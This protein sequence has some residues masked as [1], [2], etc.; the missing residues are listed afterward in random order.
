MDN[1]YADILGF[2]GSKMGPPEFTPLIFERLRQSGVKLVQWGG[3]HP[4]PR[5]GWEELI[6]EVKTTAAQFKIHSDVFKLVRESS[7]M[8]YLESSDLVHVIMTVQNPFHIEE[9]WDR[10]DELYKAGVRVI[11]LAY[12]DEQDARYGYGFLSPEDK[13]LTPAGR[14]YLKE[15]A[16]RGFIL[17]LSHLGPRSGIEAVQEYEGR[18][19]IS[20]T[21]CLAIY[22][23]PRNA[24]DEVIK[25][26][27][28][29][30][31]I[32]GIY[33]MTFFLDDKDDSMGPWLKHIRH[34][35]GLVGNYNI[36]IG[37]DA[38]V[39]GFPDIEMARL[40]FPK[41]TASLD[42]SGKLQ[43]QLC[44]RWPAFIPAF[45]GIDRFRV[46]SRAL[47]KE[48]GFYVA[49]RIMGKNALEFYRG[50]LPFEEIED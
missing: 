42:R 3:P 44:P 31:G 43:G 12:W 2:I 47:E 13:G 41:L 17:D 50:V 1:I 45:D 40:D 24:S 49:N 34:L 16:V 14:A 20:H 22:N 25:I 11:Q 9:N 4:M 39:T 6:A 29:K 48:L 35:R 15:L 33:S 26:V 38:P 28:E 7:D 18:V 10:L 27:A 23:Y 36:A 46:M 8:S 19:M 5:G 37:S 21:G 32:I 30:G